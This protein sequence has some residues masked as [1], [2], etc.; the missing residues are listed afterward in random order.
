MQLGKPAAFPGIGIW[1]ACGE[2]ME[3]VHYNGVLLFTSFL[4][5]VPHLDSFL[6][7]LSSAILFIVHLLRLRTR[8][9]ITTMPSQA[10]QRISVRWLPDA[11][12][13]DTDT[14][15]LN[16]GGYFID[17][18]VVKKSGAI[19][20]SRAGERVVLKED[21]R[22]C[23]YLSSWNRWLTQL[24]SYIPMDSHHRLARPDHSRRRSLREAAEWR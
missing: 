8:A 17:L 12:Y 7:K 15:A 9:T 2:R 22:T 13:E 3:G 4:L 21:P 19:Q 18:R 20:W 23:R 11:A 14:V 10:V 1:A 6:R 16:V 24:H 5:P